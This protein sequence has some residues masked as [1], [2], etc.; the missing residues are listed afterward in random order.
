[1]RKIVNESQRTEFKALY[2]FELYLF[3][4]TD[5]PIPICKTQSHKNIWPFH[6]FRVISKFFHVHAFE[7]FHMKVRDQIS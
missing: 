7:T 4:V 5:S 2:E 1:M 3:I 6:I